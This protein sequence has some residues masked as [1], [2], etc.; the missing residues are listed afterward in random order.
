MMVRPQR[1]RC[2]NEGS[3]L[4]W[5]RSGWPAGVR[6][7]RSQ[8]ILPHSWPLHS[9]TC[10]ATR[11]ARSHVPS[12]T[13]DKTGRVWM[14]INSRTAQV[15]QNDTRTIGSN[16]AISSSFNAPPQARPSSENW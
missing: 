11:L 1:C 14:T 3:G 15:A 6:G 2:R 7:R 12:G 9:K 16:L 8:T 5:S 4:R 13:P 10:T